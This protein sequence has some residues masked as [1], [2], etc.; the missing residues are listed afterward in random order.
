MPRWNIRSPFA[1]SDESLMTRVQRNDD[2]AFAQLVE[3]RQP[4]IRRLCARMTGDLHLGEEL[5]QE[6]FVRLFAARQT[7][8]A[9]SKFSTFLWRIALNLCHDERR[10]AIRRNECP[11]DAEMLLAASG[12]LPADRRLVQS[13]RAAFVRNAVM[14]LP[15]APSSCCVTMR[16]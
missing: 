10:R 9:T 6:T 3:R 15:T 2:A 13:E 8:R 11:L 12:E 5:C 4:A 14:G 7:Y 16:T 1:A